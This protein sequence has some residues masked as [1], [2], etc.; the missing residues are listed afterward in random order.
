MP[1][2]SKTGV[3]RGSYISQAFFISNN[4]DRYIITIKEKVINPHNQ[5]IEYYFSVSNDMV[6]WGNWKSFHLSS[7]DFLNDYKLSSLYVRFMVKMDS[8]TELKKPYLQSL[9]LE[10]KPFGFVDN[11]GDLPIKPK[12]WIKKRNGKG[13]IQLINYTTGQILELKDLNNNEEVYIDCENEEIVSSNQPYGVYRYDSHNDE[14]FELVRGDNLITS[15]GDF[16]LDIR[17]KNF[18]IQE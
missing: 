10:L 5:K 14:F 1:S 2:W 6:N 11:V 3:P 13:S 15:Y 16:D 12:L 4:L 18:L 17:Y 9:D 7:H 8:E